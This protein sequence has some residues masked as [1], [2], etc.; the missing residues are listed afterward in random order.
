MQKQN[1]GRDRA[2]LGNGVTFSVNRVH[3]GQE[4]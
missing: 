3:S 2:Y 4:M 1:C